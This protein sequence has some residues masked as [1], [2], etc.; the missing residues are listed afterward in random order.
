MMCSNV[1]LKVY[2]EAADDEFRVRLIQRDVSLS[3]GEAE[4]VERFNFIRLIFCNFH[5]RVS[6]SLSVKQEV[7]MIS[8]VESDDED[9]HR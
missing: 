1:R 4:Q 5:V 9:D 2:T 7:L 8:V 6:S 3:G